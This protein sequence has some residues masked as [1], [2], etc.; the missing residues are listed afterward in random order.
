MNTSKVTVEENGQR[1][2][3]QTV[4][5]GAHQLLADEPADM[6]GGDA[7]PAPYDFL[8]TALGACTSM[9]L[10]MYAERKALPL[11]KVSVALRHEKIEI[12]GKSVDRIERAITLEG[13]LNDELRARMLEIAERCPVAR[14]LSGQVQ[15]D[16]VVR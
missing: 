14:T 12:D 6:G 13:N 7:G 11:T 10:R 8:L 16:S 4:R 5:A 2:Y 15:I 1:R 9:T 3:Q